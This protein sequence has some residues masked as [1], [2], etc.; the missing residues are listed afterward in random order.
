AKLYCCDWDGIA[1]L[2]A[3]VAA[4]LQDGKRVVFPGHWIAA[5]NSP[6]DQLRAAAIWAAD[7][8]GSGTAPPP[9]ALSKHGRIRIAYVSADFHAHAT[10]FLMAE[11]FERH[12]RTRFETIAVSHGPDDGSAMRTR[13]VGAFDHFLDVQHKSDDEVADL[14]RAMQVDIAVDLKGYTQGARLGIFQRR[15]APIQVSYLGYPGTTGLGC[16]DYV[17]ADRTVIPPDQ[18]AFYTEHVVWLPDTYQVNDSTRA[19][20]VESP[21]RAAAGLPPDGVVFCCFNSNYKIT[22][23]IFAIWMRLLAQVPGS[24]LWLLRPNETAVRHLRQAAQVAGVEPERIV[25]AERTDLASHLARLRLADLFLDTLPYN[26]HTTASDAL[27]VGVPV[28][29]C[30]G[31]AFPGRVAASLLQAAGLPEL[32][33]DSLEAYEARALELA[34]DA[35]ARAGMRAQLT[36]HIESGPVFDTDRFR[37]HLERAFTEMV[38][39]HRRGEPPA[40]FAVEPLPPA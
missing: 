14:L 26:A 16:I 8:Y 39:R 40:P 3:R 28:L 1:P 11:L 23:E 25:F 4:G 5:S 10:A 18:L 30:I 34:R 19:A 38:E 24:V 36:A 13:L 31:C 9:P 6:A 32:I 17:L 15:P 29:T 7:I 20:G 21:S 35:A 2:K 33:T 27:L 22:P 12:D 37:Q